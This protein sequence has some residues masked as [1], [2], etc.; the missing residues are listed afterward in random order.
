MKKVKVT[1][2]GR[3][4]GVWFRATT[5]EKAV[6][7]G[8]KGY[9]RNLVNGGVEFIAEGEDSKVDE[10]V[11]WAEHGPPLAQVEQIKIVELEYDKEYTSFHI[12]Y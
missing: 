1:V 3:V 8:V 11:Q 12:K 6:E 7:L 5:H 4:Q 2:S 10:L 9:V